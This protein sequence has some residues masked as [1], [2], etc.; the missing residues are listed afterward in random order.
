MTEIL[1]GD[2]LIA[3][4]GRVVEVFG[5]GG[6]GESVRY[7]VGLIQTLL[8]APGL[9]GQL[10]LNFST[11]HGGI[12]GLKVPADKKAEVEALVEA[13]KQAMKTYRPEQNP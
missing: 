8:C 7:H 11:K 13:V 4:D 12:L 5:Q 9:T 10:S 3:F 1:L 2:H 6:G